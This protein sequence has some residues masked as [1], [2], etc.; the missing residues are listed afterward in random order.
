MLGG[1]KTL[2]I[3]A[4]ASI[5]QQEKISPTRRSFQSQSAPS[6]QPAFCMVIPGSSQPVHVH[7]EL[8]PQIH[9]QWLL[10]H[11]PQQA[12]PQPALRTLESTVGGYHPNS[13]GYRLGF[14]LEQLWDESTWS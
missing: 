8:H 10:L 9:Q 1:E 13:W 14:P 7:M 12:A 5:A 2:K 3:F 6:F 4:L 11:R